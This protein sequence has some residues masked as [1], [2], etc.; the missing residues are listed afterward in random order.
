MRAATFGRR[1]DTDLDRD[2]SEDFLP[3]SWTG[4]N[5]PGDIGDDDPAMMTAEHATTIDG[6]A[7]E[8]GVRFRPPKPVDDGIAALRARLAETPLAPLGELN[9]R[10]MDRRAIQVNEHRIGKL[11]PEWNR[12]RRTRSFIFLIVLTLVVAAVVAAVLAIAV[13]ALSVAVNHAVSKSAGS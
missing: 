8:G 11:E 4:P 12:L 2:A 3:Q 5:D 7:A 9:G 10:R 13:E 6:D 1:S